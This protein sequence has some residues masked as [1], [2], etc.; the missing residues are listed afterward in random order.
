M[1]HF[2]SSTKPGR[3]IS[4]GARNFALSICA[5]PGQPPNAVRSSLR[6]RWR[7]RSMGLF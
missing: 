3:I 6:A 4:I 5:M 2:S 1:K 7:I